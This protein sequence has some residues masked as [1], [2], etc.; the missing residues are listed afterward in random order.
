MACVNAATCTHAFDCML[1]R[2]RLDVH[3]VKSADTLRMKLGVWDRLLYGGIVEEVM[4]R[5]DLMSLLV[6]AGVVLF[7]GAT[8]S[9]VWTAKRLLAPTTNQGDNQR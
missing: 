4:V 2:P 9:V 3:T 1:V 7:G 6:W 5:W 8:P